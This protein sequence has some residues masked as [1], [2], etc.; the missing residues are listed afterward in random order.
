MT[1][2][3]TGKARLA[4]LELPSA[5]EPF[6][7]SGVTRPT[8]DVVRV[9]LE[10]FGRQ[11]PEAAHGAADELAESALKSIAIGHN[12]PSVLA[13][14]TLEVLRANIPRHCA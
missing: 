13:R 10:T 12:L 3:I 14:A 9:A 5:L 11:D 6:I 8:P 7:P 2:V 4:G 1:Y